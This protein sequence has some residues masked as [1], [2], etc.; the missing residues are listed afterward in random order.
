MNLKTI[1]DCAKQISSLP[2][3]WMVGRRGT[4]SPLAAGIL[5]GCGF[6]DVS[7]VDAARLPKT[8]GP[9]KV[10]ILQT[11]GEGSFEKRTRQAEGG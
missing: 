1:L 6:Y 2:H 11:N 5:A 4:A 7:K 10:E 3:R 9:V 8:G